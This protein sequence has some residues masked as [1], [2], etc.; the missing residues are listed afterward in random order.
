MEGRGGARTV[1]LSK[2]GIRD[3]D[4]DA[5]ARAVGVARVLSGTKV[6]TDRQYLEHAGGSFSESH[7]LTVT[8]THTKTMKAC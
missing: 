6:S 8:E 3:G 2:A 5:S 4:S 7:R 1:S